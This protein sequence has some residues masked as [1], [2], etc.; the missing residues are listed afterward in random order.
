MESGGEREAGGE[1]LEALM[2]SKDDVHRGGMRNGRAQRRGTFSTNHG[3][4][5]YDVGSVRAE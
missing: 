4:M 5:R 2:D 1:D 3:V